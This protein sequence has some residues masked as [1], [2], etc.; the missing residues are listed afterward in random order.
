MRTSDNMKNTPFCSVKKKRFNY[1]LASE[2]TA[3]YE[4]NRMRENFKRI[5]QQ[6]CYGCQKGGMI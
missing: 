5:R 4:K 2:F 1:T 3:K 6:D